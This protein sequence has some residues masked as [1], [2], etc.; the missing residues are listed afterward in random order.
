[1]ASIGFEDGGPAG[2]AAP[3]TW[4]AGAFVR[5]AADLAAGKNVALPAVTVARYVTH[6]Q[7]K[8][9]LNLTSPA[10]GSSVS[11]SSVTVTGTTAPGNAVYV[12]ATNIDANS[13]TT[14][15]QAAVDAAGAFSAVVSISGGTI[16]LNTVA[17]APDGATAH[18]QR[19]IVS[20]FIPGTLLL[21]V[22]DPDGD[23]NGPG[24]FQYPTSDNFK[25]G[26]FDLER[27][28]VFDSG[29]NVVMRLTL[30]D[31]T[32]TFGSPLGA[33]LVDVYVHVPDASP[34]STAPSNATRNFSIATADAWSRMIQVQGFSSGRFEDAAGTTLGTPAVAANAVSRHITITVPKSAL[35]QPAA[36]WVFTVVLTGQDGFSSDQARGFAATPQEFQ[37]GVCAPGGSSPICAVDPGTVPKAMDVIPPEGVSQ[38]TELDPTLGPVVLQ[39]VSVP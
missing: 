3:L 39:G 26:A 22:T 8:T 28:Q 21:D 33:Q 27:F 6:Q 14:V 23:D 2:S 36:G 34:T 1:V 31:L 11:T 32:P 10:A 5:L 17:V 4:S 12:S 37:F 38:A 13:A 9:A 24:T 16:V 35:G 15:V 20:D 25:P 30:R 19:S 18:D 7:G 29:A